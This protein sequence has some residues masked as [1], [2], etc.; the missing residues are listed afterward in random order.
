MANIC[1]VYEYR[2]YTG[3]SEREKALHTLNGLLDGIIADQTIKPEEISELVN[4]CSLQKCYEKYP[5]FN[6]ILP[7]ITQACEDHIIT[8]EELEDIIWVVRQAADTNLYYNTVTTALQDLHGILHGLL[9]DNIVN[10]AEVAYLQKWI[11]CNSFL[12]GMYPYDELES[13]LTQVMQDRIISQEE[14]DTLKVFFSEFIDTTTSMNINQNDITDLKTKYNIKGICA[15]CPNI[16]I[17]DHLFCFTGV[18]SRSKRADVAE[19]IEE[20]GGLYKDTITKKT[21]YLIIGNNGNPCWAY[22]CYGRKVEEAMNIRKAGGNIILVHEND[23]WDAVE[24]N[25]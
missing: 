11:E 7:V 12:Q 5:P 10:E 3:K 4:W 16:I 6:E 25:L 24:D 17:P 15:A 20:L 13:I 18:S 22:S 1:E 2:M 14:Q 8:S 9:C 19:K 21:D 23:F